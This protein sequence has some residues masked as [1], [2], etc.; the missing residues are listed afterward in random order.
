MSKIHPT[1]IIEDGAEIGTDVYIGPYCHVAS[2]VQLGD[3]VRLE[4]HVVIAGQTQI[5][6]ETHIF[7]FAS[8]GH[9][10]QDQKFEGEEVRL[11]IGTRNTIREYVTMNPGT[12]GGKLLTRVG[13]DGL[14]MAHVHVAHDCMVGNHVVFANNA[15]LG[16]HVSVGDHAVV[17]G[18]VGVHQFCRV[19]DSAFLGAGSLVVE[20]VIPFGLVMGNRAVLSG[21]NLVGLKRREFAR[22]EVNNLR[23]AYK[24]LFVDQKD[25]LKSRLCNVADEFADSPAVQKM[26]AFMKAE[27]NRGYCMPTHK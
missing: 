18:L 2:R 27:K 8:I 15:V 3:R 16:G 26:V 20:D 12:R 24:E 19:G 7:P 17:G 5:G 4:S 13:D 1:A 9:V 25:E 21:L 10:P 6:E 11:K 23:A 22:G 14:F